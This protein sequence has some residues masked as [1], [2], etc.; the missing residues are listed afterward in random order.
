MR[1]DKYDPVS[2]GFRAPLAGNQAK[3][4]GAVGSGT[5]AKAFGLDVN[6]RLVPGA[7]QTGIMGTVVLTRDMVAGDIVDCMTDGEIVEFG[8]VAGTV[9]TA[10]TATGVI[11]VTAADATHTRI[12]AT[13]EASRLIVRARK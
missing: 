6:G 8:G 2:G 9:Y 13:V 7:G 3:T 5:A 1:I 12:G 10:D 11:G 4:L